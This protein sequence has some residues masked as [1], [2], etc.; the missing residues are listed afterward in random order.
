MDT[1]EVVVQ[2][3]QTLADQILALVG[4]R[5]RSGQMV[6]HFNEGLVQRIETNTV[7]R[8]TPRPNAE[9]VNPWVRKQLIVPS[10][11]PS[12]YSQQIRGETGAGAGTIV[13]FE[14]DAAFGVMLAGITRVAPFVVAVRGL[15]RSSSRELRRSL[16]KAA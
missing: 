1:R 5:I 12:R 8:P 11:A 3:V 7:H 15:G 9:D 13:P 6:I 4:A 10:R 14:G 16:R 2:E